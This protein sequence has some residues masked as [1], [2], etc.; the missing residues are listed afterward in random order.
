MNYPIW[1]FLALLP[2][3]CGCVY[4]DA[5]IPVAPLGFYS[6]PPPP[7]YPPPPAYVP[8][9]SQNRDPNAPILLHPG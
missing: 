2:S 6:A 7:E 4:V 5:T 1:G 8:P 3:L 9:P